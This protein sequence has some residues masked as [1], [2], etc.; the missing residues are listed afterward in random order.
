M[1]Y[2]C[3][4]D[5][6]DNMPS[7]GC[8]RIQRFSNPNP[9]FDF[10][11]SSIGNPNTNNARR[12]N[13]MSNYVAGFFQST[14]APTQAPTPAPTY[15][16]TPAPTYAPTPAPTYAPTPVPTYAS[17]PAPTYAPTSAPTYAPTPAPTYATTPAPTYAPTPAPTYAPT[18]APTYAPTP[19]PTHATPEDM[20]LSSVA[21]DVLGSCA[22]TNTCTEDGRSGALEWFTDST[23]H[24]DNYIEPSK[25]VNWLV[26]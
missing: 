19:A 22:S 3:K 4:K 2:N 11:G 24:P 13:D 16:P 10:E 7:N 17:T 25:I 18:P 9:N 15:A 26:R 6:C 23:N 21:I 5:Q 8:N 12:I 20:L 14:N 1:A